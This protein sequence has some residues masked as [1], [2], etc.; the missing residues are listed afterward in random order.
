MS[1]LCSECI[2]APQNRNADPLQPYCKTC[3]RIYK[4]VE[5][6]CESQAENARLRKALE[7]ASKPPTFPTYT[8]NCCSLC[9][10]VDCRG[11]CFK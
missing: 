7:D 10:R 8:G 1:E 11:G 4:L 5:L 6:L 3:K 9:G 2:M